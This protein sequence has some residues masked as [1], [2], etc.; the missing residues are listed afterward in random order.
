MAQP[1]I[2]G[3]ACAAGEAPANTLAGVRACLDAGA[4]GMEI[5]VPFVEAAEDQGTAG[6]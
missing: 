5:D 1:L 3:H 6:A 2:I 4:D